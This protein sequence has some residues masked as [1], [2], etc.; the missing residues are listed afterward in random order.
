M[1]KGRQYKR[2]EHES[3]VVSFTASEVR[4]ERGLIVRS[5]I[6]GQ[7][8][9]QK[10]LDLLRSTHSPDP[11]LPTSII[12]DCFG[13]SLSVADSYSVQLGSLVQSLRLWFVSNSLFLTSRPALCCWL[14]W[15]WWSADEERFPCSWWCP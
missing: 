13:T 7:C 12:A 9:E 15:P 8:G 4:E 6:L 14:L 2:C 5:L 11:T 3:F 1:R 10:A